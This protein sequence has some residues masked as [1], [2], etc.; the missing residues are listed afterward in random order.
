MA[1][2]SR[3][4]FI[5][6]PAFGRAPLYVSNQDADHPETMKLLA[7]NGLRPITYQ[8]AFMCAPELIEK[9]A[10]RWFFLAGTGIQEKGTYAWDENGKLAELTGSETYEQKVR[11]YSGTKALA[12]QIYVGRFD[13][14][15][16]KL[17]GHFLPQYVAPV[18]VGV[19][20]PLR[21]AEMRVEKCRAAL[22]QLRRDMIK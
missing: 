18:V 6:V 19:N 4:A 10:E 14:V 8:E 17:H 16:F 15:S 5:E 3:D 12:I 20:T 1:T 11:V 21:E 7:D 2:K 9:L 13:G 22:A